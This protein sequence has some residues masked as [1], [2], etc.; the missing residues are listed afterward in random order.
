[1]NGVASLLTAA[2]WRG[3]DEEEFLHGITVPLLE[4]S[5]EPAGVDRQD[6]VDLGSSWQYIQLQAVMSALNWRT[7]MGHTLA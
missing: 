3:C 6:T 4:I 7:M 2:A 1:M 5:H